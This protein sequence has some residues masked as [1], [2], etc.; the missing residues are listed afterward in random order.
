MKFQ[1][2]YRLSTFPLRA[3]ALGSCL[4]V[5]IAAGLA[6]CSDR[7]TDVEHVQR[8]REHQAKQEL[9]ASVI[10]L[11]NA[12]QKNPENRDAR[13]LLGQIYVETGNGAPAEKE[14]Q[15]ARELGAGRDAWLLPLA[16]AYLLQG[17]NPKVLELNPE[18]T[19]PPALQATLRALQGLASLGLGQ[20]DAAKTSLDRA[21]K[22]QPD[23]PDAL[24]GMSQLALVNRNYSEAE[25]FAS[26]ASERD[27][28]DTRPWF[29]KVRLHRLQNDDPAALKALQQIL[30]RQPQNAA[31]LLERAEILIGQGKQDE[32]MADVEVVRKRQPNLPE[33][34]YLR[35]SLLF[36]KKD[37]I[38]AQ[39][40]LLQV[41]K[42][43][44]DHPGSLF[45]L[46]SINYELGNL[47]L[48]EQ[49]LT[50]FVSRLP[51]YLPAR[52]LLA[53]AQLKLE[54]PRPAID[55]L[56]PALAQAP[57]DAQLLAL[58]G[59]AYLQAR[60]YAKVPNTCRKPLRSPRTPPTSA[61]NWRCRG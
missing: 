29:V 5:G 50:T 61:P 21:L 41:I 11:K 47:A 48:A 46:G 56:I 37:L 40:A 43:V 36:Q 58:L 59:S 51:G 27:P 14:L 24:L 16:R 38:A 49:Y 19:D 34:N 8:A 6:G 26:R 60:E 42:V 7:T 18:A 55:T 25:T 35:G 2:R 22:L 53:A 4:G 10:E 28:R 44:P 45:L 39:D 17:Q 20:P 52:L 57:N 33:A 23:D 31:A 9:P 1:S 12:L 32:A 30:E 54:K 15:R 13:L 3:L